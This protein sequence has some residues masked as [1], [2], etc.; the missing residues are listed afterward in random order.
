LLTGEPTLPENA[1]E[2]E[3]AA[4]DAAGG[5]EAGREAALTAAWNR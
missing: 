1:M 3:N 2:A 5:T 4:L